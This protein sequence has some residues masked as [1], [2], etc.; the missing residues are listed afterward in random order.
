MKFVFYL[1]LLLG[2]LAGLWACNEATYIDPV[3]LTVIRGQVLLNATKQPVKDAT[4]KL[5]P[6]NRII[7]TDSAGMFRF[8]SVLVGKYTVQVSKTGYSPEV[9]TVETNVT[10]SP[11]TTI[12][13]SEETR[14]NSPPTSPTL[15]SPA[16][17][18]TLQSTTLTLKW[19]ATDP[20]RDS[21]I[22]DVLLYRAGSTTPTTSYTGLTADSLIVNLDYNTSY[23]WQ[24]LVKDGVNAPVNGP[25][26]SFMTAPLPDYNYI[27]TRRIDGKFQIFA[28]DT[29]GHEAQFTRNGSN[30]RPIVS[31]NRQQI[32]FISNVDT[33][34]QLYI[35][36]ADGSNIHRVTNVP[37]SGVDPVELSFCWSPDGTQLL[38]P[39]NDRLYAVR[40]DG[41][42]LRTVAQAYPGR[43][44]AA[45]DWT[46]QGNRIVT[47][48]TFTNGYNN[49]LL[50]F[51]PDYSDPNLINSR[52]MSRIGNPVFSIDG[53]TIVFTIDSSYFVNPEGRQLDARL[54]YQ[55]IYNKSK[56][57]E[58]GIYNST[59][60]GTGTG[61]GTGGQNQS[62]KPPGTND[63]DPR[64]SPNG[65][66]LIFTNT[67]NT[68]NGIRSVYI[69]A[70][71]GSNRRLLIRNA[72]M[73]YWR[74]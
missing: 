30:W 3:Q 33:D 35:M 10:T 26:W 34:L 69:S 7:Q 59:G 12:L 74:Q 4:V 40:T 42:G 62:Q 5:S 51:L 50:T 44:F 22:Y 8:D 17:N 60:S 56:M 23:L 13:L 58:V 1:T 49:E 21:L 53:R 31:P 72:E 6:T 73:P 57:A 43:I 55:D 46:P 37:I 45:C 20:N 41:T 11:L 28:M 32:A 65:A 67:D 48:T 18:S 70:L 14:T 52:R 24:V 39:N 61:T 27:F 16:T 64:F 9:A 2:G 71:N 54:F 15:V 63:L 66:Q 47:R 38:Y 68:G 19:K 25:I 29:T 36:N